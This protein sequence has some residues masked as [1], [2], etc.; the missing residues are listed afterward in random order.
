[1][2]PDQAELVVKAR[3]EGTIQLTLRNPEAVEAPE[4][5]PEPVKEA[6]K[7]VVAAAPRPRPVPRDT[8]VTVIRGTEV[9]TTKTKN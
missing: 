6:P 3:T 4:P 1:M 5:E 9:E 8:I 7:R 2:T